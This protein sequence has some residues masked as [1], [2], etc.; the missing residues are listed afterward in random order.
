MTTEEKFTDNKTQGLMLEILCVQCKHPTEHR[1]TSSLDKEGQEYNRLE[2]WSV[3]WVD[4]YQI[5]QC[6]GCKGVSFRHSDWFSENEDRYNG[7]SGTTERLYPKRDK[8]SLHTKD[9]PNVPTALRR[10]YGEVI[11]CFNNECLTLSAA[12]L[13][14]VVE[15]ICANQ[16]VLDGPVSSPTAGGG[17]QVIR[18]TTLEAKIFGLHEQGVLTKSRA[19]TLHEHRFLGNDAVHELV[20][21]SADELKLAIEIVEHTLEELYEVPHKAQQLKR[22]MANRK[23]DI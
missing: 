15:G 12:G 13:R 11:E 5:V 17:T 20:K 21:P 2:G 3:E 9:L 16:S 14:A 6:Q 19:E 7:D 18:R 22:R 23:R 10:L 1:V 4:H 8:N